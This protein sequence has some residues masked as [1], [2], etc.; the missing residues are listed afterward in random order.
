MQTKIEYGNLKLKTEGCE[1][2]MESAYDRA[3]SYDGAIL[4]RVLSGWGLNYSQNTQGVYWPKLF[5]WTARWRF[6]PSSSASDQVQFKVN[7][8]VILFMYRVDNVNCLL[9]TRSIS[10]TTIQW[11]I[12]SSLIM[13]PIK[14]GR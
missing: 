9:V 1:V 8:K 5:S 14:K 12:Y 7:Y 11:V 10:L 3:R 2:L 13:Q 6:G 4:F